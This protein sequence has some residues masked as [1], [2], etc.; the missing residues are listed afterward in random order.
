M[1]K[2]DRPILAYDWWWRA[3][4]LQPTYWEVTVRHL[5]NCYELRT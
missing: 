4:Q 1:K 2:F 3:L 5:L